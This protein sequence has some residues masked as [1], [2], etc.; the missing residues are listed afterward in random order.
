[1]VDEWLYDALPSSSDARTKSSKESALDNRRNQ[2]LGTA[3]KPLE[4]APGKWL[5]QRDEKQVS[6]PARN[7]VLL[8][9]LGRRVL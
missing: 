6:H 4:I 5:S 7:H 8:G 3:Q 2:N 9:T 1:M